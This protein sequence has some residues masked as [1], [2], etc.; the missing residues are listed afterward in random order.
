MANALEYALMAGCVYQTTRAGINWT[1]IP[2]GWTEFEHV[3]NKDSG[4]E[5]SQ[6]RSGTEIVISF[7]GTAALNDWIHGNMP[8]AN[9]ALSDQLRLAADYYLQVK[10]VNPEATI[11]FTGHS[12]GGGL[13]SLMAVLFGESAFTFDQ[14][15]FRNSALMYTT[16]DANG[17]PVTHSA[18]QD[19]R[20]YLTGRAPENLLAA[21][22]AYI[23]ANDPLNPNPITADTLAVREAR[24]TD[25]NVQ[26]EVLG[27]L[28]YSRIGSQKDIYQQNSM[29]ISS[30]DLHSQTL[31]TAFLQSG[32]QPSVTAPTATPPAHTLGQA[33]FKLTDLLGMIFDPKLFYSDPNN[34]SADAPENFLERLVKHETG[35]GVSLPADG[36][37]TRFTSDLWKLAQDGGL[38]LTDGNTAN[39]AVHDLSNALI[40]FAMQKYY[41]EKPISA[42]YKKELFTDL[43]TAGLGSNGIRFDMADV[44][45]KFKAALESGQRLDLTDAKGSKYLE[46][47]L[48]QG[49]GVTGTV[50]FTNE[51]RQAIRSMLPNLRDWY[52]Q[53]GAAGMN[54][55]DT[56]N[57]GAFMLGGAGND[58][59]WR[60]AA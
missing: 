38:T 7:A 60:I 44:A 6:L 41:D 50:G 33:T 17:N 4:F 31:L 23:G 34:T 59:E 1:P 25:I 20:A 13:A 9:G 42:G 8:L 58:N 30:I 10:A 27:Y 15:P 54:A 28:G 47:Y 26:G 2:P 19:L 11:S 3:V 32:D 55:T 29:L 51:E 43:S 45:A 24:V 39:P 16:T 49:D 52:V 37:V 57:R 18:A 46:Y 56:L 12:L 21:L 36:M 22:D 48:N 14:A 35:V 5:V 40:A 53:A